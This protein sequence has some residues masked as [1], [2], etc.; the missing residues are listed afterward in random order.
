MGTFKDLYNETRRRLTDGTAQNPIRVEV[1]SRNAGGFRSQV[2]IRQ[3][4]LTIDQP[5]GFGGGNAGPKPSE[6]L[7]ASL[8]ACQEITYRLYA[9][10]MDIP[11][12]GI[13]IEL[14]GIQDL[15]GFLAIDQGTPA[16]FQRIEGTVHLDSPADDAALA[17]LQETVD[18]H[19]P[20]LDDLRRPLQVRLTAVRDKGRAAAT[21][22]DD[23]PA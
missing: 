23:K 22:V 11:L 15:R 6:V 13:R 20:V 3:F 17:R 9:D 18:R 14:V 2:T 16:G 4:N 21:A 19:C 5:H 1:A 7:L 12:D 10:A 8:A